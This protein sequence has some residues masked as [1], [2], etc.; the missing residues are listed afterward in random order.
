MHDGPLAAT[1]LFRFD[2]RGL[3]ESVRAEARDRSVGG[4]LVATPWEARV[5]DYETRDGMMVPM[6]G[7]VAWV[8]AQGV[9]KPYWRAR[10]SR[11]DYEF[12][13]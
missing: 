12:A 4:A 6:Q 1:L 11:L 7:E 3:V 5:W 8:P 13:R 9:P 10:M 2:D